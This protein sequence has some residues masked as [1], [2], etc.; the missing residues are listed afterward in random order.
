MSTRLNRRIVKKTASYTI[1]PYLD[2]PG[3]VFTN[4]GAVGA[5]T[6]TLPTPSKGVFGWW[7][8][9]KG[10]ADQ[11]IIVTAP[12]ASTL[13][14][15]NNAAATSLAIQTA[16]QKI[17][18]EIEVT[19]IEIITGTYRWSAIGVSVGVTFTVA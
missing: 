12:V 6:F 16:S 5:I 13:V 14:T 15:F 9:F 4:A 18:G 1:L 2:S 10:V 8:R 7:Y 11:N 19:C 17:G 3:T